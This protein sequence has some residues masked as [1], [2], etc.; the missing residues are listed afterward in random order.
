M[1]IT[2]RPHTPRD[3]LEPGLWYI[4]VHYPPYYCVVSLVRFAIGPQTGELGVWMIDEEGDHDIEA[5]DDD[6]FICR[7]PAPEGI[8]RG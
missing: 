3:Q 1:E 7:V 2:M 5:F 6:Q 4:H 8:A